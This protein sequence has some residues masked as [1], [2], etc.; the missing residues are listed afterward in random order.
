MGWPLVSRRTRLSL[1]L[2]YMPMH[3]DPRNTFCLGRRRDS[4]SA[5]LETH[6]NWGSINTDPGDPA[7]EQYTMD[8]VLNCECSSRNS[9][10]RQSLHGDRLRHPRAATGLRKL[11]KD[12]IA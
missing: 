3:N 12:T 7:Y 2:G 8:L 10:R 5:Y 4:S 6:I 11:G 9:L 1:I